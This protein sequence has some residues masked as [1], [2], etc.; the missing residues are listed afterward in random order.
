M[1]RAQRFP[2][3][4]DGD[5]EENGRSLARLA[6]DPDASIVGL[7]EA[8]HDGQPEAGATPALLQAHLPETIEEVRDVLGGYSDSGVPDPEHDFATRGSGAHDDAPAG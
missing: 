7:D 1:R 8:F 5:R 2:G 3:R 6:L 4:R